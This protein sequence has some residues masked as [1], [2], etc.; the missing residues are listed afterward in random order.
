MLANFFLVL[1]IYFFLPCKHAHTF[2]CVHVKHNYLIVNIKVYKTV[3]K[4][5][6]Y[7]LSVV[8]VVIVVGSVCVYVI[9]FSSLQIDNLFNTSANIF[10]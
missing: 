1:I 10:Y 2:T 9:P 7:L 5:Y 8:V 3:E 6:Y 4:K